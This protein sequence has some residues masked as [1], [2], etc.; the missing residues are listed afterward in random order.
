MIRDLESNF[1]FPFSRRETRRGK[2]CRLLPYPAWLLRL[3]HTTNGGAL[4]GVELAYLH[5]MG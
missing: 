4:V 2:P 5:Y 3:T 1:L